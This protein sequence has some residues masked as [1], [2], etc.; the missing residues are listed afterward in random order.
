MHCIMVRLNTVSTATQNTCK[1]AS[2]SH[3]NHTVK[4]CHSNGHHSDSC[5]TLRHLWTLMILARVLSAPNMYN[6]WTWHSALAVPMTWLSTIGDWVFPHCWSLS[7]EVTC[8]K[9][10]TDSVLLFCP[11]IDRKVYRQRYRH[12]SL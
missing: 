6:Y 12:F 7:S 3:D 8:S 11:T 10:K 9:L 5:S 1:L 4:H 2:N